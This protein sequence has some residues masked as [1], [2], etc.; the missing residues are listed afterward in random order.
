VAWRNLQ[1]QVALVA[2]RSQGQGHH[3]AMEA[4]EVQLHHSQQ[5]LEAPEC[6]WQPARKD[7]LQS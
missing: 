2:F 5:V 6:H 7:R 1:V 3:M 4:L